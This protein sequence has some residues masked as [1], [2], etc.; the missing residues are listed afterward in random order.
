M[1]IFLANCNAMIGS[2]EGLKA[3]IGMQFTI[4]LVQIMTLETSTGVSGEIKNQRRNAWG[5]PFIILFI[6]KIQSSNCNS[7][8]YVYVLDIVLILNRWNKHHWNNHRAKK[9]L[10]VSQKN[11]LR[12][13]F[14]SFLKRYVILRH[15]Y[16]FCCS[17][18]RLLP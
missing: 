16:H 14:N 13:I 9:G 7:I 18:K 8:K 12:N 10:I 11:L 5:K 3:S 4:W 1:K 17:V 2:K 6:S 15:P